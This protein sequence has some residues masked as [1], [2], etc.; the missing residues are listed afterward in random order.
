MSFRNIQFGAASGLLLLSLSIP[1][2]AEWTLFGEI[3]YLEVG[4]NNHFVETDLTEGECGQPGKFYW[5]AGAQDLYANALA[6]STSGRQV[7][8]FLA[9]G[10]SEQA[11]LVAR[12]GVGA[13]GATISSPGFSPDAEVAGAFD[14]GVS[15][16]D[17]FASSTV[18]QAHD[19]DRTDLFTLTHETDSSI[20]RA[21]ALNVNGTW[22]WEWNIT[23]V[24][25]DR[26]LPQSSPIASLAADTD[27]LLA[28]VGFDNWRGF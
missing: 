20:Y 26:A 12:I 17:N 10:C 15:P 9:G 24:G 1:A 6:A 13:T 23:R 28:A 22:V 7:R 5:S 8:F 21:S 4:S 11:Q 3:S 18:P 19:I 25:L 27:V 14:D 2:S 16:A